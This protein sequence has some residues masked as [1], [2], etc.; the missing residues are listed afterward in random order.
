ML[1]FMRL[2]LSISHSHDDV[3]FEKLQSSHGKSNEDDNKSYEGAKDGPDGDDSLD[4]QELG[5]SQSL[6]ENPNSYSRSLDHQ[7]H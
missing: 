3:Y 7:S 1:C 5:T 2:K 4:H 6:Y